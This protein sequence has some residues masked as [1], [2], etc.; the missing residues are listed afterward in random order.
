MFLKDITLGID[1]GNTIVYNDYNG[2]KIAYLKSVEVITEAVKRCKEVY[3]ISK[4]NEFQRL[5]VLHWLKE[6]DFHEKTG[7]SPNNVFFCGAY[8]QKGLIAHKLGINCFI[9]DKPEVMAHMNRTVYK[10]LFCPN[11][12]EVRQFDLKHLQDVY[13]WD[14]VSQL[15]FEGNI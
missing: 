12:K 2:N 5:K 9:D 7:I 8:D 11:P 6:N 4:V 15:L 1:F 3:I 14:N 10:I 13:S